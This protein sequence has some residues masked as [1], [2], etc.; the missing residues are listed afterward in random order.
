MNRISGNV[1]REKRHQ[2]SARYRSVPR[3]GVNK[4]AVMSPLH[5]ISHVPRYATD[6]KH[7][8]HRP[9]RCCRARCANIIP[10][11][12]VA[13]N[14]FLCVA[15]AHARMEYR[16]VGTM[17]MVPGRACFPPV[18]SLVQPC[19]L[20]NR[21][22][23]QPPAKRG[24]GRYAPSIRFAQMDSPAPFLADAV[25]ARSPAPAARPSSRRPR[26]PRRPGRS[27]RRQ[28]RRRRSWPGSAPCT[29]SPP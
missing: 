21:F 13:V 25:T 19:D 9:A 3:H 10:R 2:K 14:P 1:A 23:K 20:A 18:Y 29:K 12:A 16:A 8:L 5:P 26:R 11:R 7:Y 17:H 24:M 6:S 22:L 28:G 4:Q 15:T 27:A